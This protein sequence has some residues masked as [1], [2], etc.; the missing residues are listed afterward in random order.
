MSLFP[1]IDE[2]ELSLDTEEVTPASIREY[3]I[4]FDTGQ[5]TGRVVEGVEALCVWAYLALRA[6]RYNWVIYSWTYGEEYSNLIGYTHSDEYLRSEIQRYLEECL[7]ENEHIT[8]VEDLELSHVKDK[9]QV[10]F[11]LVTDVGSKEVELDV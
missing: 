10:S 6:K 7:F 1:F 5:L 9:L 3:E 11:T 4:D 2:E 8:G